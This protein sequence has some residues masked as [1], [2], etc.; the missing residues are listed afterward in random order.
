MMLIDIK[1]IKNNDVSG[2]MYGSVHGP[3][4]QIDYTPIL[5]LSLHLGRRPFIIPVA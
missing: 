4:S 1:K 3:K 5:N 2:I